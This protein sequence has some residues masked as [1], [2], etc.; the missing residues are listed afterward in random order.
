MR[1]VETLV[2]EPYEATMKAIESSGQWGTVGYMHTDT[3]TYYD[4]ALRE[5]AEAIEKQPKACIDGL[6]KSPGIILALAE[7][8]QRQRM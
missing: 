3:P 8:R 7:M 4:M 1:Q 2:G 5:L 6:A